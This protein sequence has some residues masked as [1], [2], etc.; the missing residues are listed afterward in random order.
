VEH[1]VFNLFVDSVD[2]SRKAMYYRLFF[3]DGAGNPLTLL[4]FKDIKNDPGADVWTDTTTLFTRI[5]QGHV[6]PNDDSGAKSVAGGILHILVPDFLKQLTTFHIEGPTLVDRA[7][8]LGRFG[9]LF[10]GKLWD[11]YARHVLS[12]GP[13]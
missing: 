9:R 8:V 3:S 4:G 6:G 10:L 13:L 5:L 12:N 7:A 11:V 1:G 2:P